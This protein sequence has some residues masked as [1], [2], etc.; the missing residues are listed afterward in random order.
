[1]IGRFV[2]LV[3][4]S[5]LLVGATAAAAP[6]YPYE[7]KRAHLTGSGIYEA[8]LRPDRTV[9]KV[10]VVR[11]MRWPFLVSLFG[12][13]MFGVNACTSLIPAGIEIYADDFPLSAADIR[14]IQRLALSAGI[15]KPVTE[16]RTHRADEVSVICGEPSL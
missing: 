7:A 15:K 12:W 13:T 8:Y 9:T 10:V 14:D 6:P 5:L 1:M 4:A 11:P 16:L 2:F 3:S